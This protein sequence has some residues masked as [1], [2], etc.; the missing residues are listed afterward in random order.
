MTDLTGQTFGR[1][2]VL[3]LA[4]L[5]GHTRARQWRCRCECGN[6][7]YSNT[8][9]LQR[10]SKTSCG[11]AR[12]GRKSR[13]AVRYPARTDCTA[14]PKDGSS[15]RGCEALTEMLCV[16]KGRCPFYLKGK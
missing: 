9:Y 7:T 5:P 16:T 4:D 12:K 2:T 8:C 15:G 3:E 10:G 1:L 14:Y 6:I 11:C 13:E